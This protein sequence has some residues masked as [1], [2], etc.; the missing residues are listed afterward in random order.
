MPYSRLLSEILRQVWA[1]KGEAAEAYRPNIINILNGK[2]FIEGSIE[3]NKYIAR[4]YAGNGYFDI[5]MPEPGHTNEPDTS[6]DSVLVI[7][8]KGALTQY[9]NM[10]QYGTE[11][12]A[13]MLAMAESHHNILGSVLAFD[14]PGGSVNSVFPMENQMRK[15]KK[16]IVGLV[17]GSMH[18]AGMYLGSFTNKLGA[19]H[20]MAEV[21]SIGCM[22]TMIDYREQDKMMGIKISYIYPPESNFKNKPEQD[23]MDG[24]PEQ[25]IKEQ[26]SPWAKHF[27][28]VIKAN[29]PNLNTSVEGILNGKIF[30]AYDAKENGLIDDIMSMDDAVA[31]V[32]QLA[33]RNNKANR[34]INN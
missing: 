20:K 30:Y 26:L 1:I 33:E 4:I 25:L 11:D 31:L 16:P 3:R 22:A 8:I 12:Y 10:C 6:E 21:G 2:P 29:R 24:K 18:S 28:D 27:Q 15:C 34:I 14:T 7:D 17:K 5:P 13:D 23:A 19:V 9:G 32:R